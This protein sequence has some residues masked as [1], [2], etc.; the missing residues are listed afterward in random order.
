MSVTVCRSD[1]EAREALRAGSYRAIVCRLKDSS[2]NGMALM[3]EA[4][5]ACP[6]VAF[7][8]AVKRDDLRSGILAMISG[9]SDFIILPL[10]A[11]IAR[12]TLQR[13]MRTK[14]VERSLAKPTF[15]STGN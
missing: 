3:Y 13:A 10:R 12:N 15:H 11:D 2:I 1:D 9:A 14:R 8:M 5:E 7:V 4:H 6:D